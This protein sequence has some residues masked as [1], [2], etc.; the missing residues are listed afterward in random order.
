MPTLPPEL[1]VLT[2][3]YGLA[4]LGLSVYNFWRA[5]PPAGHR[6]LMI[7]AIVLFGGG[8]AIDGGAKLGATPESFEI[9]AELFVLAGMATMLLVATKI[10]S[11]VK[12]RLGP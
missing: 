12:R 7:L 11:S 9:V 10:H 5:P 2:G 6:P 4:V 1:Y 8:V 3:A